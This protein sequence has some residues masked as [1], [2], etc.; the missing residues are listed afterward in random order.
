MRYLQW[1]SG[2]DRWKCAT[3]VLGGILLH[4]VARNQL[5]GA[6]FVSAFSGEATAGLY[7][8]ATVFYVGPG[9]AFA[10]PVWYCF[11]KPYYRTHQ[12]SAEGIRPYLGALLPALLLIAAVGVSGL[13]IAG[14]SEEVSPGPTIDEDRSYNLSNQG[15]SS[16]DFDSDGSSAI[17]NDTP[18]SPATP[19]PIEA[20]IDRVAISSGGV[21]S[22]P[23][24]EV[25]YTFRG[26]MTVDPT[27]RVRK[28]DGSLLAQTEPWDNPATVSI[29]QSYLQNGGEAVVSLLARDQEQATKRVSFEGANLR[30]SDVSLSTQNSEYTDP[31]IDGVA[32][33]IENEGDLPIPISDIEASI[34]STSLNSFV[35]VEESL[36]PGGTRTIETPQYQAANPGR[37]QLQV[38][39]I[40]GGSV[41]ATQTVSVEIG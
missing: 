41:A 29:P 25:G 8:W 4:F 12:H 13:A 34:G 36:R 10:A 11:G 32:V 5:I 3:A 2:S 38:S 40:S 23:E 39:V 6:A 16:Y 26:P 28:P 37:Y 20:G 30:I 21:V 9:A 15:A 1:P 27:I 14:M 33:T 24:F 35:G 31:A 22:G 17:E 7:F 18:P 19:V